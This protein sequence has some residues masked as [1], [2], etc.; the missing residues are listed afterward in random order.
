M[1]CLV[2]Q[3]PAEAMP[4]ATIALDRGPQRPEALPDPPPADC[5]TCC[6]ADQ[7]WAE[8]D[9]QL[10]LSGDFTQGDCIPGGAGEPGDLVG[11]ALKVTSCAEGVVVRTD[12][13]FTLSEQD[14]FN[15]YLWHDDGGLPQDACGLECALADN[16][17]VIMHS[18]PAWQ[19]IDWTATGCDC[20]LAEGEPVFVGVVYVNGRTPPDWFLARDTTANVPGISLY[21]TSA[22]GAHGAWVDLA[23]V[24]LGS[25]FGVRNVIG[26]S[27]EP[28]SPVQA[29]SWGR[30][31]TRQHQSCPR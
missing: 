29:T 12:L 22:G 16:P 5:L 1:F 26:S 23:D 17:Q 15:V 3:H 8:L 4:D 11:F 7:G 20:S 31:K 28:C 25:P 21:N 10:G 14:S 9:G 24:G 6:V 18:A 13:L 27:C 30:I 19:S 2:I